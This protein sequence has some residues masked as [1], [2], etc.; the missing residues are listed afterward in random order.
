MVANTDLY[1]FVA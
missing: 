1:W